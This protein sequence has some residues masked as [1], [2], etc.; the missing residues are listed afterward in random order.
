MVWSALTLM[1]SLQVHAAAI[2]HLICTM[3]APKAC[4]LYM[5]TCCTV[6]V[7]RSDALTK[8]CFAMR[9]TCRIHIQATFI[10]SFVHSFL[11]SFIRSFIFALF[12][13]SF[14]P[15]SMLRSSSSLCTLK[16]QA[17]QVQVSSMTSA[18]VQET[19]QPAI[20]AVPEPAITATTRVQDIPPQT[21]L[22][23]IATQQLLPQNR[24]SSQ[25]SARP[26][27]RAAH[28]YSPPAQT[29]P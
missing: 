18:P 27:R 3:N 2:K 25:T 23:Q 10:P 12:V 29:L 11:P 14:V 1:S 26:F 9:M 19:T 22:G 5:L 15:C 16:G 13:H 6:P 28:Q 20:P 21:G 24:T 8:D 7:S 4:L 17:A